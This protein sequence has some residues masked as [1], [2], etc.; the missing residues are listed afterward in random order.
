MTEDAP[1][2]AEYGASPI[3]VSIIMP[4]FNTVDYVGE[5]IQSVLAQQEAAV[6]L[7]VVDDSSTDG[8]L[9]AVRTSVGSDQRV[10]IL[11]QPNNQGVS[12]ARNRG[13]AQA[14]GRYVLFLDSDDA[15]RLDTASVLSRVA[16]EHAADLVYF[17]AEIVLSMAHPPHTREQYNAFYSRSAPYAKPVD[18]ARLFA[19]MLENDD[20]RPSACLQLVRRDWLESTGIR[21]PEGLLHEDNLFSAQVILMARRAMHLPERLYRRRIRDGS[22]TSSV[23]TPEHERSLL[24]IARRFDHEAGRASGLHR[25]LLLRMSER[26]RADAVIARNR[27]TALPLPP[28]QASR[29]VRWARFLKRLVG[30]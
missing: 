10:L 8:S 11:V 21:F 15:L 6:E 14:R 19:D 23:P 30:R 1:S 5:A 9:E 26:M 20:W 28:H 12:A 22:I 4:V 3:D 7:I 18:G 16:D 29:S 24:E 13:L 27:A 2:V 17:D 25:T